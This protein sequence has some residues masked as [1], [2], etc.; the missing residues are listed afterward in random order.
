MSFRSVVPMLCASMNGLD[1]AIIVAY[2]VGTTLF[3]CSFL[4]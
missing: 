3:G 2:L 4:F 1:L